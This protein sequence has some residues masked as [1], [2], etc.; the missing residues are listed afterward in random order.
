MN[1]ELLTKVMFNL[2]NCQCREDKADIEHK[3]QQQMQ[4][5]AIEF[6]ETDDEFLRKDYLQ[7]KEILELVKPLKYLD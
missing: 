6:A 2:L 4:S 5:L 3:L 7:I 1:I